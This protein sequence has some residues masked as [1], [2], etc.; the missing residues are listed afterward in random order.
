[1]SELL[2]ISDQ[3]LDETADPAQVPALQARRRQLT[4]VR[5]LLQQPPPPSAPPLQASGF[6]SNILHIIDGESLL[7]W[8]FTL[9]LRSSRD[10]HYVVVECHA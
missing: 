7:C 5:N 10:D 9:G 3:L 6:A 1:M 8:S 2:E 4:S